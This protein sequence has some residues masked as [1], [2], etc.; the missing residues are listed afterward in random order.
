MA[1]ALAD[2]V[3]LSNG[4][5]ELSTWVRPVLQVLSRRP[6]FS[7]VS[8]LLSPCPHAGGKEQAVAETFPSVDRVLGPQQFFQF[9]LWGQTPDAWHWHPQGV[10]VFLGGDQFYAVAIGQRLGYR[11]VTYAEWTPRWLPWI[12]YCGVAQPQTLQQ[13]PR[14]Y[15]S[16]VTVV[17]NLMTDITVRADSASFFDRLGWMPD[18]ETVG[19]LPGSKPAKLRVGVPFCLGVAD[20]LQQ[21]RPQTQLIIAVAPGLSC[22]TLSRYADA[23]YNPLISTYLGN[24]A[25]LV[26]S[27]QGLPYLCTPRGT[28]VWL[29]LPSPAY[30]LLVHCQICLTTVGAN[31]AELAAL[32]VPMMVILPT[33]HLAGAP[34]GEG[35]LG[36]LA[37]LPFVGAAVNRFTLPQGFKAWPNIWADQEIVP[38]WVGPLSSELVAHYVQVLL[39][40]PSRLQAIKA[41]LREVRGE[42]GAVARFAQLVSETLTKERV[43]EALVI[44]DVP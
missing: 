26:Q 6:Q 30:D 42:V 43:A 18:T 37:R 12:D 16:K 31:T 35:V 38:E 32:T 1:E 20:Q 34:I 29:W 28:K 27:D 39:A 41:A 17:G 21:Y 8:I 9:L 3:I 15:R 2:L 44:R 5:G 40:S 13:V 36:L 22:A 19:L 11:I 23:S 25:T 33:Q 14:R 4:P 24:S 10:V 7:R